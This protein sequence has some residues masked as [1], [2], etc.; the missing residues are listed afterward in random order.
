MTD[1]YTENGETLPEPPWDVA[2][3]SGSKMRVED[4]RPSM[5]PVFAG[6]AREGASDVLPRGLDASEINR[7]QDRCNSLSSNGCEGKSAAT[8]LDILAMVRIGP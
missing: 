8:P 6:H 1:R 4:L 3:A 2:Q 7:F 5:N